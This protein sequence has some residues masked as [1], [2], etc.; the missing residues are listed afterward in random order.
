MQTTLQGRN[1]REVVIAPDFPTVII[2]EKI[3]P[4]GGARKKIT[5]ALVE[6]NASF[7]ETEALAQVEAGADV[8]DVN[9]QA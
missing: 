2:G 9:V 3:N 5:R 7:I 6:R 8:L 4:S 1:G